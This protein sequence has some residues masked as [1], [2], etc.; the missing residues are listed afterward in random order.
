MRSKIVLVLLFIIGLPVATG[1][2]RAHSIYDDEDPSIS[3]F[4]PTVELDLPDYQE[5]AIVQ[6]FSYVPI[7]TWTTSE[8]SR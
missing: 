7:D 1:M 6:C 2:I 3:D 4:S 5:D 8:N